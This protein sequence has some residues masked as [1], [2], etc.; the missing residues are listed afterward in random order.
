[1]V[2]ESG[3]ALFY[4][5]GVMLCIVLRC[6]QIPGH[7][8]GFRFQFFKS[9][10]RQWAPAIKK[11]VLQFLLISAHNHIRSNGVSRCNYCLPTLHGVDDK[12]HFQHVKQYHFSYMT[13]LKLQH[14]LCDSESQP[15]DFQNIA[16]QDIPKQI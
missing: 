7:T 8:N 9:L 13:L 15:L 3:I 16:M 10:C 14:I 6:M 2:S 1:M 12:N 4:E 5:N 11:N